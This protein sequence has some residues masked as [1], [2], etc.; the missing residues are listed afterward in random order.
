[1]VGFGPPAGAVRRVIVERSVCLALTVV[2]RR[3]F[4][5]NF[6]N[7]TFFG[8]SS[9]NLVLQVCCESC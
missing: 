2:S 6:V 5:E 9:R 1:M 7:Q 3:G 4:C 8:E